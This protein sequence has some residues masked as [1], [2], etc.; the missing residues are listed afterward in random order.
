MKEFCC[1]SVV[2]GCTAVFRDEDDDG[3]M[4]QVADHALADHLL[5]DVPPE[6]VAEVRSQ[7]H[8]ASPPVASGLARAGE[9]MG[10]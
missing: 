8:P 4:V 6:L 1:G 2:P 10:A 7:I 3:I 9:T 5:S